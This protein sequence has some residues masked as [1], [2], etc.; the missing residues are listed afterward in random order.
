[1]EH[2]PF[3]PAR[4]LQK[5]YKSIIEDVK[6][7]KRAVILT[8][9]DKP[10]AALV[11]LEDLAALKHAKAQQAAVTM[12]QLAAESREALEGLPADLREKANDLLY[13]K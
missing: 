1:M 13:S 8:T 4:A 2:T 5:Y 12:L 11:S 9:N 7:S 6:R 10:Q 3:I